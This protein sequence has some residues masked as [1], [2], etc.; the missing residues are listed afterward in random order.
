[1]KR[2]ATIWLIP[3]IDVSTDDIERYIEKYYDFA[4]KALLQSYTYR[5]QVARIIKRKYG[6]AYLSTLNREYAEQ[7]PIKG[8]LH[9]KELYDIG[10]DPFKLIKY[11]GLKRKTVR[12]DSKLYEHV[13]QKS[14]GAPLTQ[15]MSLSVMLGLYSEGKITP[16][17]ILKISNIQYT[18][19]RRKKSK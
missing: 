4:V 8:M 7:Y 1:M 15:I 14:L 19:E 11:P 13:A 3:G 18:I 10:F 16:Q 6:D 5:V 12:I 9:L 2:G 17:D